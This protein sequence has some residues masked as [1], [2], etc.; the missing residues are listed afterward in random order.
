MIAVALAV[1]AGV[2]AVTCGIVADSNHSDSLTFLGVMV[3]TTAAQIFLAGAIC[4]WALFAALWLLS[5]G[6]RRSRERTIELRALRLGHYFGFD[7][8]GD[9]AAVAPAV[10]TAALATSTG[11]AAAG[12]TAT[13]IAAAA[14]PLVLPGTF[15]PL[16]TP[17]TAKSF[18]PP[19]AGAPL[20]SRGAAAVPPTSPGAAAVPLVHP[21]T[22]LPLVQPGAAE[23]LAA[24]GTA[25]VPL[26]PLGSASPAV[27]P[28]PVGQAHRIDAAGSA[29]SGDEPT[30]TE[31]AFGPGAFD[32]VDLRYLPPT[33]DQR[34]N[35]RR[36]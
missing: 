36:R 28:L 1:I 33:G 4:T 31:D 15:A 17:G 30:L 9:E 24:R 11:T 35:R 3:K 2:V 29:R 7:A 20:T 32:D 6:V 27:P 8:E 14:A 12:P 21:G 22:A 18:A 16:T 10:P 13:P 25:A 19:G 5:V 26:V 23:P 34:R